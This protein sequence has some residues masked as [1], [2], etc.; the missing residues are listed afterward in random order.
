MA[1]KKTKK[2]K[3]KKVIAN[4]RIPEI[5]AI[6]FVAFSLYYFTAMFFTESAGALGNW[7]KTFTLGLISVPGYLCPILLLVIGSNLIIEKR[8][9][10]FRKYYI[11]TGVLMLVFSASLQLLSN[12]EAQETFI[13]TIRVLYTDGSTL[14]G[15]GVIGGLFHLALS[16]MGKAGTSILYIATFL[17]CGVILFNNSIFK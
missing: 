10:K 17:I 6:V 9:F 1:K 13:D 16:F 5:L 12:Y 4:T 2:T 11:I 3:E 15:G 7:I 14:T 8:I